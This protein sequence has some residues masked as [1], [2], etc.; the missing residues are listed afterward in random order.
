MPAHD[1]I[2]NTLGSLRVGPDPIRIEK[3][4]SRVSKI[5]GEL[6]RR[7]QRLICEP[8]LDDIIVFSRTFGEHVENVGTVL[9]RLR[10]H[11]IKLK[12]KNCRLFK[13]EVN[14]L[15]RIVS[16]DGYRVDSSRQTSKQ[17]L[18]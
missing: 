1:R 5:R 8:Y 10:S 16:A 4:I 14:Y 17:R 13:K 7:T 6:P 18:P 2:C 12:S 11:E 9:Q 15:G 3:R